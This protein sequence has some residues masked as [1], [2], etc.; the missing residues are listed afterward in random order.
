MK[1]WTAFE[2]YHAHVNVQ[3]RVY[4]LNFTADKTFKDP[5]VW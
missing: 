1:K 5:H 3:Q 4:S 2:E